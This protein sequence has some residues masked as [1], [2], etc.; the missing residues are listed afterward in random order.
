VGAPRTGLNQQAA[1][2]LLLSNAEIL[3]LGAPAD[4]DFLARVGDFVIGVNAE[5]VGPAAGAWTKLGSGSLVV[6]DDVEVTVLAAQSISPAS[7][8]M[9]FFL[10]APGSTPA[11]ELQTFSGPTN[12]SIP[13]GEARYLQVS[14]TISNTWD[15]R[16]RH[17]DGNALKWT[18][19]AYKADVGP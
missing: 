13:L 1:A 16:I 15:F 2:L 5:A 17:N 18:W 11:V 8:E 4:G 19:G 12:A 10:A 6:A 3:E 9:P 7:G 14:T